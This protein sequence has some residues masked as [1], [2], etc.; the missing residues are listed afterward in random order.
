MGMF[1]S[2]LVEINGKQ[3]ELQ[4]KRFYQILNRYQVGS[5]IKG[6]QPGTSVYID[7][8]YLDQQGKQVYVQGE[9]TCVYTV[10]VVIAH[11]VFVD[12]EVLEKE[13][14][15]SCIQKEMK[16]LKNK[17]SDSARLMDFLIKVLTENQDKLKSLHGKIANCLSIIEKTKQLRAG[18]EVS[19][20]NDLD[21]NLFYSSYV[22]SYI[23]RD[24]RDLA[25]VGDE[26]AF[27]R[28]LRSSAARTGQ[29]LNMSEL[30]RDADIASN[31]AK[32]WLSLLQASGTVY[33]LEP[34]FSNITKR[35]V[36]RPKLYFLDTGL[37][38]YLT[39]WLTPE[40]LEAGAMS[41]AIFETWVLGELLKSYWHNGLKAPFFYYRDKD[42]KEMDLIIIRDGL[43]YPLEFKKT[44]SPN[45]KEAKNFHLLEK[46][47]TPLG[48][49]GVISLADQFLP[50]TST[51]HTI[52]VAAL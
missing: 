12:Y 32:N 41:G 23:Q 5:V 11:G 6:A 38:S 51:V 36:K 8:V 7:T 45:K 50:L 29:L 35:M 46:L 13:L 10:F 16:K 19:E 25:K 9:E 44:A 40:T 18:Q 47:K 43:L 14:S 28:F 1:D 27:V 48:P 4:T 20:L 2:L 31:T 37:C 39:E 42:Q 22:Q 30:A 17:W 15:Y 49:G 3:V 34:Y 24:I 26:R 52:P 21:W 33:L